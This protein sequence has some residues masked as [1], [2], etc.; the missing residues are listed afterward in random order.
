ML[1]LHAVL[2]RRRGN[3]ILI[4]LAALAVLGAVAVTVT[5]AVTHAFAIPVLAGLIVVAALVTGGT[6]LATRRAQFAW[7]RHSGTACGAIVAARLAVHGAACALLA[8]PV[9]VAV[10]IAGIPLPTAPALGPWFSRYVT[11]L[12]AMV[13]ALTVEMLAYAAIPGDRILPTVTLGNGVGTAA[14]LTL[15]CW[16]LLSL[17]WAACV[18]VLL[19]LTVVG[20]PT[21]ATVLDHRLG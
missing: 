6:D 16:L 21:A 19:V 10:D 17:S 8:L 2:M 3:G 12:L 1:R 7:E 13:L 15:L 20:A 5:D 9:A 14:A 18:S 4:G 11:V